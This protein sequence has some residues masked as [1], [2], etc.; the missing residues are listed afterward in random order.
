M[1]Y[2]INM[3]AHS[4]SQLTES[5]CLDDHLPM[6]QEVGLVSISQQGGVFM[7]RGGESGRLMFACDGPRLWSKEPMTSHFTIE[8]SKD[9]CETHP[10]KVVWNG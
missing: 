4:W 3:T 5:L 8:A 6:K 1:R 9:G 2:A 7:V 10:V